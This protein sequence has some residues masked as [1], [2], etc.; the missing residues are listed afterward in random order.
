MYFFSKTNRQ[1]RKADEKKNHGRSTL[2]DTKSLFPSF[3][4]EKHIIIKLYFTLFFWTRFTYITYYLFIITII[5]I[6]I[7]LI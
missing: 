2:K 5:C 3:T 4:A 6:I 1:W 7:I